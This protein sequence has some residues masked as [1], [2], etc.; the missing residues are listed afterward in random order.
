MAATAPAAAISVTGGRA[1]TESMTALF[2]WIEDV[3]EREKRQQEWWREYEQKCLW[4][5]D[6]EERE[7]RRQEW[8]RKYG[9]KEQWRGAAIATGKTC[10]ECGAGVGSK[11]YRYKPLL[12]SRKFSGGTY[13][14]TQPTTDAAPICEECAP[15]WLPE[16]ATRVYKLYMY[17]HKAP[18]E[19]CGREVFFVSASEKTWGDV[20]C[21]EGCRQQRR[22]Q[23]RAT[24]GLRQRP[25]EKTCE[26]CAA[27]FVAKRSDAKTCSSACRQR[28]YRKRLQV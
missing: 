12:H 28:A 27:E 19:A 11:V 2:W 7:K 16:L 3:E 14:R 22:E 10:S 20:F 21:S 15:D 25:H 9:Q 5:F 6:P 23:R 13:Y 17:S 18:C 4:V 26:V 8:W 1:M 24:R